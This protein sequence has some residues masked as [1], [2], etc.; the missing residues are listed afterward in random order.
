MTGEPAANDSQILKRQI[1]KSND[2]VQ[3]S[4]LEERS[5]NFNKPELRETVKH[6]MFS[7]LETERP[8]V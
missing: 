5:G 8:L 1:S 3:L 7:H 2:T 4:E 6:R